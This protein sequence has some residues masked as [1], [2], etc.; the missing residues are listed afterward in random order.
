MKSNENSLP[1]PNNYGKMQD[2]YFPGSPGRDTTSQNFSRHMID[3][4]DTHSNNNG[5]FHMKHINGY[6]PIPPK[7]QGRIV[8]YLNTLGNNPPNVLLLEGGN[9]AQR[10]NMALYWAARLNCPNGMVPCMQCPTC[11]QIREGVFRDVELL[12]GRSEQ[13]LIEQVRKVRGL[14]GKQPYGEGWRV[15]ILAEAQHM[16][17]PAANVLLKSMEEP[18]AGNVFI[19]LAPQRGALL[20]TLVSRSFTLTLSWTRQENPNPDLP[21]WE[22]ALVTFLQ[23]GQGWF[24]RTAKKDLVDVHLVRDIIIHCQTSLVQIMNRAPRTLLANNLNIQGSMARCGRMESI[25]ALGLKA[26]NARVN[27][28]LVLDWTAVRLWKLV[29]EKS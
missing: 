24:V 22:Q 21:E 20:P 28:A 5:M 3:A 9:A 15:I 8:D 27:P 4:D 16:D 26:L 17:A 25:L 14:M 2:T 19:L 7:G 11:T 1:V 10:F 23:K 12:D 18:G 6:E 29:R 13:I